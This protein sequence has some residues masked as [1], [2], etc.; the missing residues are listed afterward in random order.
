MQLNTFSIAARCAKTGMLGVAVS[1]AVVGVGG[2]CPF[3]RPGVGAIS[4]QAWVNPYLGLDG[5]ELLAQGKSAEETV[6][7]LIDADPGRAVRQ[8]GVVDAQ[9]RSATWTGEDCVEWA[10]HRNGPDVSVQGNM[11]VGSE[12][13]EAMFESFAASTD[14][15][16]TERL[17]KAL[18]AGQA[19]GGDKRGKQSAGMVVFDKELYPYLD[20]RVDEHHHPVGE[21]RRVFEVAKQQYLPFIAGMPTRANPLG[22]LGDDVTEMLLRAPAERPG[23]TLSPG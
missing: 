13:V 23:G 8:L 3:V 7:H 2:I 20:L 6:G 19:V 22:A 10:G 16:L 14:D 12:T 1:T 5:I 4:T 11:L 15:A 17:V 9:G 18:E 21:L